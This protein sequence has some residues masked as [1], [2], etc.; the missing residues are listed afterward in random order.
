MK[1]ERA[2]KESKI[3]TIQLVTLIA[4]LLEEKEK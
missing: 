4:D 3:E 1:D 2:S